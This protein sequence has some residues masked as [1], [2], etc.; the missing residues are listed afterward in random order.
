MN[1]YEPDDEL[2]WIGVAIVVGLFFATMIITVW[3]LL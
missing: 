2:G 3:A 1:E